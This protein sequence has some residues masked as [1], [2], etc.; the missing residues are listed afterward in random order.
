[1]KDIYFPKKHGEMYVPGILIKIRKSFVYSEDYLNGKQKL[2]DGCISTKK[3]WCPYCS[4]Y[5]HLVYH[6]MIYFRLNV[7]ESYSDSIERSPNCIYGIES[8][9]I[10]GNWFCPHEKKDIP[11][12]GFNN[13]IQ[14]G[15]WVYWIQPRIYKKKI[16]FRKDPVHLLPDEWNRCDGRHFGRSMKGLQ[17]SSYKKIEDYQIVNEDNEEVLKIKDVRLK[18]SRFYSGM[19]FFSYPNRK[20]SGRSWKTQKKFHQWQKTS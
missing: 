10:L 6:K 17:F 1:M 13:V 7:P 8:E 19:D 2:H 20:G 4:T 5:E 3:I 16:A 18:N 12:S 14:D 9:Y 11:Y 15:K